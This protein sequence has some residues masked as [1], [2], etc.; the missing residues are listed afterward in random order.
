MDLRKLTNRV[1]KEMNMDP[2]I[3]YRVYSAYW[4]FIKTKIE[5][6]PLKK[7]LK[8]DEFLSLRK[9]FNIHG[10]GKIYCD[11]DRYGRMKY[12]FKINHYDKYKEDKADVQCI[13]DDNG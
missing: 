10:I 11:H 1:A 12:V 4:K 9:N 8:M 7:N 6:L 2:K 5:E 3:V 13:G